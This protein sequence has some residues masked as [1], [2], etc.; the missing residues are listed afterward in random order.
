MLE[1]S[2][3]IPPSPTAT[4]E[5]RVAGTPHVSSWSSLRPWFWLWG[6]TGLV[7]AL[8]V[9]SSWLQFLSRR[10]FNDNLIPILSAG[11]LAWFAR[12]HLKSAPAPRLSLSRA[13]LILLAAASTLTAAGNYFHFARISWLGFL[14]MI[15]ASLWVLAGRSYCKYW[16]PCF[17][18]S[19]E[20][21][22]GAP[23][24]AIESAGAWLK[25][26][27]LNLTLSLSSLF[28]PITAKG[29]VFYVKGDGFE[30]TTACCGLSMWAGMTFVVLLWQLYNRLTM[31]KLALLLLMSTLLSLTMNGVRLCIT[32]LVS[33]WTNQ[34]LALSIHSNLEYLLFPIALLVLSAFMRKI[35]TTASSEA[36]GYEPAASLSGKK[37][38]LYC[39]SVSVLL[40]IPALVQHFVCVVEPMRQRAAIPIELDGWRG[41]DVEISAAVR[42]NYTPLDVKLTWRKYSALDK[43]SVYALVQQATNLDNLHD[44]YACL[45]FAGAQPQRVG[46]VKLPGALAPSA[47]LIEY[48]LR[49]QHCYALFVYQSKAGTAMFPPSGIW[50][51]LNMAFLGRLPCR[52]IELNTAVGNSPELAV[53]RLSQLA[54]LIARQPL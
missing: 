7:L 19:L 38:L 54:S 50:E 9:A 10:S 15:A 5:R 28:I 23:L 12:S 42:K 20:L 30:I 43:P 45:V 36:A 37:R 21:L 2:Q 4:V 46:S 32:A 49:N 35:G 34:S 51:Q 8:A 17:L 24:A 25:M 47:T 52:L 44:G 29:N 16:A 39:I 40:A 27:S 48:T 11:I 18:F 6:I 22:P 14:A 1:P 33:Y 53:E 26:A 13:G 41:T 3:S 31:H